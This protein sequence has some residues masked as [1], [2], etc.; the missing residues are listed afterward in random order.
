MHNL[1][2]S[3]GLLGAQNV[4]RLAGQLETA[5]R[6]NAA[7]AE[8][9][10]SMAAL[11]QALQALA[12]DAEP[13]LAA[14][15]SAESHDQSAAHAAG[16]V[17]PQDMERL[18]TLLRQ[19]DLAALDHFKHIAPALLTLWGATVV[20]PLQHAIEGFDFAAALALLNAARNSHD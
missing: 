20:G 19:Q 12:V 11:C 14:H 4:Y 9:G 17:Q 16:P 1:R 15:R 3:A 8:D 10:A 2:G 6:A 5:L 18:A 13:A 7:A